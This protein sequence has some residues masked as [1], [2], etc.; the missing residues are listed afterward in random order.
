MVAP[1]SVCFRRRNPYA[2]VNCAVIYEG[3]DE[4]GKEMKRKKTKWK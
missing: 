1:T 2:S 4:K 3:A